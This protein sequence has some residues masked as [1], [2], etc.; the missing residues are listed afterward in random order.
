MRAPSRP[1]SPRRDPIVL[2][3][4]GSTLADMAHELSLL[5][6]EFN[7]PDGAKELMFQMLARSDAESVVLS[8]VGDWEGMLRLQ[9]GFGFQCVHSCTSRCGSSAPL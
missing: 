9:Y 1:D 3:F 2:P 4:E 7:M 5:A 8:D 6:A